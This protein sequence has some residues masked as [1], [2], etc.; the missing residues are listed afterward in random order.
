MPDYMKYL[1]ERGLSLQDF[2]DHVGYSKT[3]VA[4]VLGGKRQVPE[5]TEKKILAGFQTCYWCKNKWPH[6]V[7]E[8]V[9]LPPPPAKAAKTKR[10]ARRSN[11]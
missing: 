6:P 10:S 1:D 11:A 9:H 2:A 3:Y 4:E 8:V 7:P 5:E